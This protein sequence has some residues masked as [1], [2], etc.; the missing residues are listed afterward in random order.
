MPPP[1]NC[2]DRNPSNTVAWNMLGLCKVSRGDI[3]EGIQAYREALKLN[4]KLRDAW[5]NMAQA[6]KEVGRARPS[7][8]GMQADSCP[9]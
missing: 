7:F 4:P 1:Q 8:L 2:V 6:L 3:R 9:T 5:I